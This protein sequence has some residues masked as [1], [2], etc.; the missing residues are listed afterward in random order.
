[1]KKYYYIMI[2]RHFYG[3]KSKSALVRNVNCHVMELPYKSAKEHV[4]WLN[5]ARYVPGNNESGRPD[6]AV[7]GTDSNRGLALIARQW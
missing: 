3:E 1:M 7:V 5:G 6:Y 2:T 4:E